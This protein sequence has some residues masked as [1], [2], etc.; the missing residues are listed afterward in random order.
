MKKTSP[1]YCTG[2]KILEGEKGEQTKGEKI[3]FRGDSFSFRYIIIIVMLR[4]ESQ[5]KIW[6][7]LLLGG[8]TPT[9]EQKKR[10]ERKGKAHR[11]DAC[12]GAVFLPFCKYPLFLFYN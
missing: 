6:R 8:F 5:L 2:E 10:K 12:R 11:E 3:D 7:P 4:K 1:V 9:T